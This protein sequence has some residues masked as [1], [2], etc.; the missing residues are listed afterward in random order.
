LETAGSLS[1]PATKTIKSL[2]DKG[3]EQGMGDDDFTGLI[4]LLRAIQNG[5]NKSRMF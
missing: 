3:M 4:R 1:L 5:Q 2:Y